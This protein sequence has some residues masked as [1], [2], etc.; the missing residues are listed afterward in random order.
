V[1]ASQFLKSPKRRIQHQRVRWGDL[2]RVEFMAWLEDGTLLDS[3]I[4]GTPLVF[5]P[6]D[7]AVMRGVERLVIGMSVGES[8][9]EQIPPELAYGCYRPELLFQVRRNWLTRHA[10]T[11][12]IGMKL[13]FDKN[14]KT[15]LRV[16]VTGLTDKQVTLD[17][18]H[19]WAGQ[20][21]TVQVDLLE[22]VSR[23]RLSSP[24]KLLDA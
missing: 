13:A 10:V 9:T 5:R 16:V 6:G 1:D 12:T 14:N 4:F 3:T 17:A 24:H 19:L 21:I 20:T 15:L 18:N 22:I 7:H 11:P 2:V 23:S 8:K